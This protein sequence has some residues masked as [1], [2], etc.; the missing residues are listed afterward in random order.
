MNNLL[1][2]LSPEE[3]NRQRQLVGE[4]IIEFEQICAFL[5]FIILRIIN[6]NADDLQCNNI[7]ILLEGLTADPLKKKVDALI[8]DNHAVNVALIKLN[9]RLSN[10]F[11]DLISVRNTFAHGTMIIGFNN[12]NG[13]LS[14]NTFLLKHTKINKDGIDRNSMIIHCDQLESLIKQA[15]SISDSYLDISVLIGNQ[16]TIESRGLMMVT[17]TKKIDDIG[18]IE[19]KYMEKVI[20]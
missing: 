4:F 14:G 15:R 9:K 20:K 2:G 10:K 18:K 17:L 3:I 16:L 1:Q 5:R 19:L 13:E 6:P 12:F 7:E 11:T 8:C